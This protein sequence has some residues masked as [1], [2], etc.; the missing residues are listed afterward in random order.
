MKKKELIL[1][2]MYSTNICILW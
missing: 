1:W 2:M